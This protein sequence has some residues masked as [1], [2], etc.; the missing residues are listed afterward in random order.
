MQAAVEQAIKK[1]DFNIDMFSKYQPTPHVVGTLQN[2]RNEREELLAWDKDPAVKLSY[3]AK[4]WMF[5]MPAWG[6]KG[7]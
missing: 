3:H 2:L 7:T 1:I 5:E 6:Y 4:Q